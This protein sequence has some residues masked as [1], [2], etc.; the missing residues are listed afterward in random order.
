[1]YILIAVALLLGLFLGLINFITD[2]L[3]FIEMDYLSV[4]LMKLFTQL[5]LGIPAF[6]IIGILSLIY[7][8]ALKRGYYKKVESQDND[9]GINKKL[10]LAALGLSAAFAAVGTFFIASMTWFEFLKFTNSTAFD[11]SDPLYNLDVSFYLFK[12]ELIKQIN[13]IALG[14]IIG[15]AAITII[16]YMLMMTLRRPL[17]FEE[18]SEDSGGDYYYDE[19][20][21]D[22]R[23]DGNYKGGQKRGGGNSI[24]EIIEKLLQTFMGGGKN[25]NKSGYQDFRGQQKPQG[26]IDDDNFKRILNI[27]SKQ[28]TVIGVLFFLMVGVNFFLRQFDLLYSNTGVLYGA[29]FTDV[30]VTLWMYRVLIGLS[31]LGAIGFVIGLRK[32]KFRSMLTIP[33]IMII[34]GALGMGGSYVVQNYVVSPDEIN[35]ERRYLERNIEATRFAYNLHNVSQRSFPAL[36]NLTPAD[37]ANNMETISNIRINDY[38]PVRTFYN[39]MQAIRPYYIFTDV[40]V[41]RYMINGEY[42]QVYVAAREI[43][44]TSSSPIQQTF[45]NRHIKYTH[46][47]GV[48]LSRVDKIT[49]SGLPEMLIRNIPPVSDVEEIQIDNASIYFGRM[50]NDFILVNTTEPEFHFP[51]GASDSDTGGGNAETFYEGDAGIKMNFI[52]KLMFSIRERNL[53][54]LVSGALTQD[55]KIVINRNIMKRVQTIM[56]RLIYDNE[57]YMVIADGRLFWI[58]DAYTSSTSYPY[59]EPFNSSSG[60]NYIRNSVKIVIDAFN[61]T[62]NYY[63]V[64]D[65]DPIALTYQSIFPALFKDLSEMPE[66]LRAHIRY[67]NMMLNIQANVFRRYHMTD[68]TMFYQNEDL[69]DIAKE[70]YGSGPAETQMVPNYYIMKLPGERKAEFVNTIPFT[71]RDRRNMS[72]LLLARNDGVN[73]SEL[74][75]F[76]LPKGR[77][78]PGPFQVD[79]QIEQDGKISQDFALWSQS[80]STVNRGNMFVVPIENSFLYV[81]PIYLEA[82]AGSIPEVRRVI[83]AYG[84]PDGDGVRIAYQATLTEALEE[85]FGKVLDHPGEDVDVNGGSDPDGTTPPLPGTQ[86][87]AE[88]I[89]LAAKAFTD[90]QNAQRSGDWAAYGRY[91]NQLER[92]LDELM[93]LAE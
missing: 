61:G 47:Y 80:G 46:G 42:T 37:I 14:I 75:L 65:T 51:V 70:N 57:P 64:D 58:V 54:I 10:N 91:V 69:W 32:K 45:L 44:D 93:R 3:W 38:D 31:I 22:E 33:V 53:R 68:V 50:T 72:G 24:D 21:D 7:L 79:A 71:P 28:I 52:N 19:D 34:I 86:T 66:Y 9:P 16:Y 77:Q 73:Y 12:L 17:I 89:A 41:D 81:K 2:L 84:V 88:L 83:V 48:T 35:K 56:P 49:A 67:P 63:L 30:N 39:N 4:F 18:A 27:A 29:G 13:T 26:K 20:D 55:S 8:K 43:N 87:E 59:S 23:Y 85:L 62:T 40:Y 90:A 92:Y 60:V 78:I 74:V 25:K 1:M 11:I 76:Q 6:L 15:F 5:K 36:T 82:Q